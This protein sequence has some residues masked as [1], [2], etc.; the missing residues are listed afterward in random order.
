MVNLQVVAQLTPDERE[1]VEDLAEH[2]E[3]YLP[4][5]P[6]WRTTYTFLSACREL[7]LE[8]YWQRGATGPAVE[9]LLSRVLEVQRGRFSLLIQTV[10]DHGLEHRERENNPISRQ[11]ID[12]LNRLLSLLTVQ[13]PRYLTPEFRFA[14]PDLMQDEK[15]REER[16]LNTRE[17]LRADYVGLLDKPDVEGLTLITNRL[18]RMAKIVRLDR[19]RTVED[20]LEGA[21]RLGH[22][23]IFVQG[24]TV[25]TVSGSQIEAFKVARQASG[26]MLGLVISLNGFAADALALAHSEASPAYLLMDGAHLFR[27]LNGDAALDDLL[28]RLVGLLAEEQ[29][30]YVPMSELL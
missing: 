11:D 29:R 27:V 25:G 17:A 12:E 19:L 24:H 6:E 9:R 28:R 8:Q 5:S 3:S 20:R 21:V 10:V 14:R 1:H 30:P 26:R 18:L 22:Y 13:I 7:K 16:E 4:G 15:A 2:L 23:E